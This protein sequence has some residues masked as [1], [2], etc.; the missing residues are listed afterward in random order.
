MVST[1][2]LC[3]CDI[4]EHFL[5]TLKSKGSKSVV[6]IFN[7]TVGCH[8]GFPDQTWTATSYFKP[9]LLNQ[10]QQPI[11]LHL[12]FWCPRF[13]IWGMNGS[14]DCSLLAKKQL[15][16]SFVLGA[17][18][19]SVNKFLCIWFKRSST[20]SIVEFFFKVNASKQ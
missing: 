8:T 9:I 12:L 11:W 17:K 15:F 13:D 3:Y 18:N 2:I 20:Y 6:I 19:D 4:I 1:H 5:W 16:D 10:Y 7:H 14:V